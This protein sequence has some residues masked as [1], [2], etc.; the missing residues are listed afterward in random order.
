MIGLVVTGAAAALISLYLTITHYGG[1]ALVCVPASFVDCDAVTSSSYSLVPFTDIPIALAGIGWSVMS[2][3]GGVLALRRDPPWLRPAHLAWAGAA[4]LF[5][6]YLI[7]AE[8]AV[9]GR[10]CEW[11]TA[12]HVLIVA[13]FFLALSRMR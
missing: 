2:A 6:L 5:A 13:T 9:I 4:L 7:N 3:A 1:A 12:L 8:I 10:I 11:C